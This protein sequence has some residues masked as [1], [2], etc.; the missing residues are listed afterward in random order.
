MYAH[1][2]QGGDA[3]SDGSKVTGRNSI[4]SLSDALAKNQKQELA[5]GSYA[6]LRNTK[7]SAVVYHFVPVLLNRLHHLY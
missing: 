5:W 3:E 2:M 6:L 7:T 1:L 4:F